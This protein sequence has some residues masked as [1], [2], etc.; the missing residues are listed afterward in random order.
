MRVRAS[1]VNPVDVFIAAGA[2]KTMAEHEF[3]VTLGRDF[4]GVV[5]RVGT[6]VSCYRVGDE[7]FGFVLHAN[8]AVHQGS[9]AELIAVPED[10]QVAAKPR[11]VDFAQAGAAPLAAPAGN[12]RSWAYLHPR[13]A[14]GRNALADHRRHPRRAGHD[15][16]AVAVHELRSVVSDAQAGA[17]AEGLAE[18]TNRLADI[19]VGQL[20]NDRRCRDRAVRDL[21]RHAR[22]LPIRTSCSTQVFSSGSL[23]SANEP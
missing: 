16:G 2:L 17:E 15:D 1:S 12:A 18:P 14:W 9:W 19:R 20:R 22:D 11:S 5:E 10:S 8:P 21:R 23:K 3:P 6:S 7:V 13:P 4:A